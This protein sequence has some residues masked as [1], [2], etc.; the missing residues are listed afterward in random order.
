VRVFL[1]GEDEKLVLIVRIELAAG[2]CGQQ[3]F[4]HERIEE[5]N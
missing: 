3:L 1:H 5:E 2:E 4:F